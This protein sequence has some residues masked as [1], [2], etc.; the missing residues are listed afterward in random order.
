MKPPK[1]P[2]R[3]AEII[4]GPWPDKVKTSDIDGLKVVEDLQYADDLTEAIMVQMMATFTENNFDISDSNFNKD[5]GFAIEVI[6]G[7]IYRSMGYGHPLQSIMGEV[8]DI[9]ETK[10][11]DI[12]NYEAIINLELLDQVNDFITANLTNTENDDDP[13]IS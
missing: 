6:K 1:K 3:S 8:L 11:G 5:M 9:T 10:D 13:I 12:T 4:K 2:E 7:I